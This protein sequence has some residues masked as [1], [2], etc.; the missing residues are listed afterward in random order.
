MRSRFLRKEIPL[1]T[2]LALAISTPAFASDNILYDAQGEVTAVNFGLRILT[3]SETNFFWNGNTLFY[4]AKEVPIEIKRVKPKS[5]VYIVCEYDAK[6]KK[7]T[8]Q[9]VYL[10]PNRIAEKDRHLYPFME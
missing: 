2:V 10:L 9:K 4:D 6:T 5:W 3:L 7:R 1:F 8:A